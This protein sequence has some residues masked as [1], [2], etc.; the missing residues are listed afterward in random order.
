MIRVRRLAVVVA[1][2]VVGGGAAKKRKPTDV[3][4]LELAD[5]LASQYDGDG[6]GV[7][8][9]AEVNAVLAGKDLASGFTSD[10]FGNLDRDGDGVATTTEARRFFR[11]LM[12]GQA[13]ADAFFDWGL[14]GGDE[15]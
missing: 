6:D 1:L 10:F 8:T 14:E 2:V 9:R 5:A 11:S 13:A 12:D 15:L 7:I 4:K 3:D